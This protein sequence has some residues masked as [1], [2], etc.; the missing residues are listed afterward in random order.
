MDALKKDPFPQVEERSRGRYPEVAQRSQERHP[1]VRG[2]FRAHG[3]GD[4]TGK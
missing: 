3:D 2:T 1:W 4:I